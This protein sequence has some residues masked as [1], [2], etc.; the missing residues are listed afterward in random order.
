MNVYASYYFVFDQINFSWSIDTM[1]RDRVL[2]SSDLAIHHHLKGLKQYCVKLTVLYSQH[3]PTV[4]FNTTMSLLS[5]FVRGHNADCVK[6]HFFKRSFQ[7]SYI[8]MITPKEAS[9]EVMQG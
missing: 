1:T 7:L 5:A 9:I 4:F 3:S 2:V 8:A 6:R